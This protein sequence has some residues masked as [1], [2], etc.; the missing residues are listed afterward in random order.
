MSEIKTLD[1]VL[2]SAQTILGNHLLANGNAILGETQLR[3][4]ENTGITING[5]RFIGGV[6]GAAAIALQAEAERRGR[7]TALTAKET[8]RTIRA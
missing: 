4:T 6:Y 1:K 8:L 7:A 2:P 5:V 3:F